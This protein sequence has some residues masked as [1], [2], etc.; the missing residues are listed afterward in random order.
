MKNTLLG[1]ALLLLAA[2]ATAQTPPPEPAGAIRAGSLGNGKLISDTLP[3]AVAQAVVGGCKDPAN[4]H[5]FVKADPRGQPGQRRWEEIWVVQ[6][7]N[8]NHPVSIEFRE[9]PTGVGYTVR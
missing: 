9:T 2:A 4:V 7:G 5:P 3:A 1:C 6:C 8:G